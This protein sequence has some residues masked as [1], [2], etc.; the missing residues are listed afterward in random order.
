MAGHGGAMAPLNLCCLA[1]YARQQHPD[2][3]FRI[4][5]AE[6]EGISH[7]ETVCEAAEFKPDLIGIT[8]NT[9]VFDSVI[10]LV[11][12]LKQQF[13][14]TPVLLGGPH[15]SALPRRT[16]EDCE[17]DLVAVGEGERTFADTIGQLKAGRPAW[18]G[19]KG[20][21]YR[22]GD[23]VRVNAPRPRIEDLDALPFPARDLVDNERYAPP[24]TKRVG[25]G[26]S[27]MI[28]TSR[29]CP[30]NCGFCGARAVWERRL[31]MR[32]PQSV[33]GEIE[34][35]VE[36]YGIRSFNF[37]D[38]FFTSKKSR[39]LEICRLVR[40]RRLDIRWVC[41]AR[42]QKLDLETLCAMKA[43]GCHEISY[44]IESGN[45]AILDR[46]E[47]GLDLEE[48]RR[49]I[50]LTKQADITTHA[51]YMFG[52]I[53]ETERTMRDTLRFAKSVNTAV[54]AFFV[55]SP[56]PGT[57][58]YTEALEK[59]CLRKDAS[60]IDYSPL[61]NRKPVLDAPGLPA[62]TTRRFHRKALRAYYVRP[63]YVLSRLLAIRHGYE[64]ANLLGGLRLLLRIR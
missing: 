15:P 40:E 19:V 59:G 12:L 20:L 50:K 14:D 18:D 30:F 57:Q 31:R 34:E 61:S 48:A 11:R 41:S 46:M 6:V 17:A 3:A 42:A 56:L 63:R 55:A 23:A 2:V 36:R 35:C 51:S 38:E 5:D 27:T 29:G 62:E 33:V 47:K 45:Q 24:P 58:L 60:W 7:E 21:A 43:A 52:Y 8:V 4:L 53:G 9:C 1:A 44:G 28:A 16:L 49:V 37:S 13:P 64:V 32:A 26:A 22:D 10:A 54:A 39:V 25:L